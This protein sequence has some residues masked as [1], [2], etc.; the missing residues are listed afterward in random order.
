[1][2]ELAPEEELVVDRH[3][4]GEILVEGGRLDAEASRHLGQ[5]E[6]V[7]PLF[8]HDVDGDREDLINGLLASPGPPVRPGTP[9]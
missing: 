9:G 4:G 2:L 1:M 5:A 6:T 8:G 7:D 3:Q